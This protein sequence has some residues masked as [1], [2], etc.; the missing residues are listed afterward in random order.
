MIDGHS[1]G[2]HGNFSVL[3][4]VPSGPRHSLAR[5]VMSTSHVLYYTIG[6]IWLSGK[7]ARAHKSWIGPTDV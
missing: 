1:D 7:Y 6:T 2:G 3:F 4:N 5:C